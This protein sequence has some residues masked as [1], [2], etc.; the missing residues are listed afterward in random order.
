MEKLPQCGGEE[1][2]G[3]TYLLCGGLVQGT[4]GTIYIGK[5]D[6]DSV[7]S[8]KSP[9]DTKSIKLFPKHH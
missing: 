6:R 4:R 3:K 7:T 5:G 2:H 9:L 8:N 1:N